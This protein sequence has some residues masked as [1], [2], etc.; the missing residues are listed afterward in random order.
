MYTVDGSEIWR[1]PVEVGSLSQY[2]QGFIHPRWLGMGFLPSTVAKII[3]LVVSNIFFHPYLGKWSNLT[4]IFQMGWNHQLVME[5]PP[6]LGEL[7]ILCFS[8]NSRSDSYDRPGAKLLCQKMMTRLSYVCLRL[9]ILISMGHVRMSNFLKIISFGILTVI[10]W[11]WK[12]LWC[13]QSLFLM[14]V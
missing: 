7:A 2:L 9:F 1:S 10:W 5:D 14:L 4:N 3:W 8:R 12:Y 13:V 6:N 11:P